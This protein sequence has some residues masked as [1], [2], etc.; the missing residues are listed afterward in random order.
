MIDV[1]K[2]AFCK[3]FPPLGVARVGD[4]VEPDG[5]FFAPETPDGK[6]RMAVGGVPDDAFTYRD[7]S[8]AVRRQAALFHIYAFDA[9][10]DPLGELLARHAQIQWT[11][12]L[13]NKKAAWFRFDGAH[14]ARSAFE[15]AENPLTSDGRVLR[16]RNEGVGKLVREAGG[17]HGHRF[18]PS[19]ERRQRLEIIAPQRHVSG[20]N[21]THQAGKE[22]LRF[23]G[24]F[25]R[26]HDVY[27]GEIATDEH[28]RL[29]VLGGHG[30][31]APVDP[32]GKPLD[33]PSDAWITHYANND[34]WCDD[35]ADGPVK[36]AVTL[37]DAAGKPA[38][39]LEV[40]GGGWVVV[41]PPDFAPDTTNVVTLYDV[42][43]E[44]AHDQ[45]A[46]CNPTTPPVRPVEALD[47]R[48]DIWPIIARSAGYRWVSPLGLRGHGQG[49]P[50]DGFNGN[51]VSFEGFEKAIKAQDGALGQRLFNALRPP[52]YQR[53]NGEAPSDE[54]LEKAGAAA[55]ALFMPPLSGD[56]G[57]RTAG[58]ARTWL[59]LTYLQYERMRAWAQRPKDAAGPP[60]AEIESPLLKDGSIHP[61]VL[62]RTLLDRCCGGAFFPGIEVTSIVRDPKLYAEA[63]R[64][65]PSVLEPG[66]VTKYMACPW[67]AD[68]YEC[69]DAWWPAQRP[70]D[71][72]HEDSFKEIFDK[73]DAEKT[74]D[75]AG[76]FEN[77]LGERQPWARGVGDADPRPSAGFLMR[78]VFPA[79]KD[80][81]NFH[82][83]ALRSATG[84]FNALT[85]A[86][87][88]EDDAS[89]WRERYL[90]QEACDRFAGRYFQPQLPAPET[91]L[92]LDRIQSEH[93]DMVKRFNIGSLS[94]V[95]QCW[96]DASRLDSET[97]GASLAVIGD[98]YRAAMRKAML[99]Y[100]V[101]CVED[102]PF[103]GGR[104]NARRCAQAFRVMIVDPAYSVS[105]LDK[106]HPEDAPHGAPLYCEYVLVELR[107]A[108][109]DAAYLRHVNTNGDNSMVRKWK[110]L[111][112]VIKRDL[113]LPDGN[114]LTVHVE[115]EREKYDGRNFRDS[116]YYLLNIEDHQDFLPH[117]IRIAD[118]VLAY[119]QSVID[120]T[121]IEDSGHPESFVPYKQATFRAKLE[122]IYEIQ[123]S[124][125][126][127]FDIYFSAL[128]I[129]LEAIDRGLIRN[130]PFNQC[131]GAWL[132][133][134]SAAGPGDDV[135]ALLFQVWSDEI[136][137][138]NPLLH[139]GN[140]YTNLLASRGIHMNAL[141]T[142]AY[143]DDP[144]IPESSFVNP[145]FQL[146]ISQNTDRYFPELM[147]MTLFLEWEVLSL[148]QGIRL[149][150]YLG[151]DS[152]FWQMHVGIDNATNG[153]GAKAR[154]AVIL[155]LDRVR[156]EGGEAAVDAH[157][158][159]IWR[160]FVAFAAVGGNIFGDDDGVNRR[161]PPNPADQLAEIMLRKAGYGSLNHFQQ[162]LGKHRINDL[163]STPDLFQRLLATSKWIVPG[164]PDQSQFLKHLT[165]FQGPMYQIFNA[166]D[167]A[168]WRAWIAWLG[169]DGET[170]R[171]KRYFDKAQ[172]M[173][174]LL[175]ELKSV[176]EGVGAHA[177]F[178]ARAED[179]RVSIASLFASDDTIALMRA[180]ADVD[181]GWVTKG[182]PAA[183]PLVADM[184]RGSN[185]MGK[186]LD[187]R[188]P[189]INN[190]IG[191]QIAIEWIR[192]GCPI[193][194]DA[195][196]VPRQNLAAPL[197]PLGPN[198]FMHTLGMGAVH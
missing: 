183:S 63:F 71:V 82:D 6:P 23:V 189:G 108:L 191:R 53:A 116:F 158:A 102:H 75:L 179:G 119:A 187:R 115:T 38:R 34:N 94:D 141:S 35:T 178:K 157:W 194:G 122:E 66:D 78:Q 73:F 126:Q 152:H 1:S 74:G 182:D 118:E 33:D 175:I 167:L 171:V 150:D 43:E 54:W 185:L 57:D 25:Q 44:V 55:T 121:A 84:W 14:G 7:G 153:H 79:V 198:L 100:L 17:A 138:G 128:N 155:Y 109:Q 133:N 169:R 95:R 50:G 32:T 113:P 186:A 131:D 98:A 19:D 160:G 112:F 137:N 142:R 18:V 30:V 58:E 125:A 3:I 151:L 130:A 129:N 97:I 59:S 76:Q 16:P 197:K 22:E 10:G 164:D 28:G 52:I 105:R 172:A 20:S 40:R 2:I 166:E 77:A 47:L 90:L 87:T 123:R 144:G 72:V 165:T 117:T 146:A 80:G 176:A 36:A 42:M 190:R 101:K 11:V 88:S 134:I 174:A 181:S 48:R 61:S 46:L 81:E 107:D 85:R 64:F 120:T 60:A 24:K 135:R 13:A 140:L 162:R 148:V 83:Y 149:Y 106:G 147:G 67:Q 114:S 15:G 86:A 103:D 143:A 29:I 161:R 45:R 8:G 170:P 110:R 49:R 56:E 104:E 124:R 180:L 62:T 26:A 89:P 96:R 70:D 173:E 196:A 39:E 21:R 69:R 184:M 99:D 163:F 159:R 145:V 195:K 132:R 5:Y 4:S 154:D 127:N 111:G 9:D 156:N 93:A 177:R 92:D 168:V 12:T 51:D 41:A 192:A 65:D 27:L 139:H 37:L 31:S 136:G 193:P 91:V 188:F 68:F